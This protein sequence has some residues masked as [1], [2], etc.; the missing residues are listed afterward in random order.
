MLGMLHRGHVADTGT[1]FGQICR[2]RV[3]SVAISARRI[4]ADQGLT[5]ALQAKIF[6]TQ[7]GAI[8]LLDQAVRFVRVSLYE[9]GGR[10][11]ESPRARH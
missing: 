7:G 11:F 8:R 2:S 1:L 5:S 3:V 6:P 9:P 4:S 10:E